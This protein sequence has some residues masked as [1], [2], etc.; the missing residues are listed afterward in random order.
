[1]INCCTYS[2]QADKAL[3]ELRVQFVDPQDSRHLQRVV[4]HVRKMLDLDAD[5]TF[6]ESH[7]VKLSLDEYALPQG[8][9]PITSGLRIPATLTVFEAACRAVQYLA[10][11]SAWYK[12]QSCS[13]P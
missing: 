7:I 1:M 5:L 8:C 3:F 6:I 9:F 12:H 2:K 10:S 11:K 4:S 13:I